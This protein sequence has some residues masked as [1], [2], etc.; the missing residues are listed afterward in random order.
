MS[1]SRRYTPELN[2]SESCL[3]GMSYE[4]IIPPGV[5]IKSGFVAALFNQVVSGAVPSDILTFGPIQIRGR[6][7]YAQITATAFTNAFDFQI[8]WIAYDTQGNVWP[9][10]GLLLCSPTS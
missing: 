5:G 10:V 3:I 1:L 8:E 9:R 7:L 6:V 2:P 4:Y